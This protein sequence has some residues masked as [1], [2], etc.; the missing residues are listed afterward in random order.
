MEV[1]IGEPREQCATPARH[2]LGSPRVEI[3][4]DGIDPVVKEAHVDPLPRDLHVTQQEAHRR[5][6]VL[7]AP[8]PPAGA[9]GA[10]ATGSA[11]GNEPESQPTPHPAPSRRTTA[12]PG[13]PTATDARH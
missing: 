5:S 4:P 3:H 13:P 10:R 1:R 2:D 12:G 6:P 7:S 9:T 8:S 11:T